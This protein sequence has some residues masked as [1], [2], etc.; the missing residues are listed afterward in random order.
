MMANA[1]ATLAASACALAVMAVACRGADPAPDRTV[2]GRPDGRSRAPAPLPDLSRM[3]ASVR[4]QLRARHASLMRMR[5][6]ARVS[7]VELGQAYG[8]M[9][10]LLMA[11]ELPGA[12]E[13]CF[14]QA[15]ALVPGEMRWPYYL[16]HVHRTNGDLTG[17]ISSFERA[18]ELARDDEAT[19]MWLGLVYLEQGRPDAA[20][21]PFSRALS[22]TP[23]NSAAHF[24][25][26]RAALSRHEYAKAVTHL[27][28][29]LAIAPQAT[30]VHYS[31]ALAYRGTGDVQNADAHMR[32][33]GQADV[34]LRDPLMEEVAGLLE[35]PVS[36]QRRGVQALGR[37]AWAEAASYFR[38]GLDLNPS[39]PLLR[40]SL[41]HKLGTALF[42]M[43]DMRSALQQF[44]QGARSSPA[45]APNH[46]SLGVI[47]A[48]SG[49]D[50]EAI[51]HFSTAL[52]HDAGY[53]E[54]HLHLADALRRA[55]RVEASRASYEAAL[56]IDPRLAE[57][58]FGSA[59]A[60]VRLGR[61]QEAATR[62][63]EGMARHPEQ[64]RFTHAL[65]RLIAAA[66]DDRVRDGRRAL[67]LTENLQ[68]GGTSVDLA[69]TIAMALAELGRYG[70]ATGWQRQVI[71]AVEETGGNTRRLQQL[72]DTLAGY[73]RGI[74]C[75]M[76]W[77]GD[78]PIHTPGPPV[79]AGVLG[80]R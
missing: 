18:R 26:G 35:S 29:A 62:L 47:M 11:A 17:A 10:R 19:L 54:A 50:P 64:R 53:A 79:Q 27:E 14:L 59:M 48:M 75:R 5:E 57:A 23:R 3:D 28:S 67:A 69:E 76:P 24:G 12:A 21:L 33:Q 41:H 65:A 58:R 49:R 73:E 43:G 71:A 60:L 13:T 4:E 2:V 70:D 22:L 8:E 46:A 66:Q 34:D 74:P 39:S 20:E 38:R 6:N 52:R 1:S 15:Q 68:K 61:E 32:Q 25:L 30:I 72:R 31:L 80:P 36:Y 7:P 37:E 77:S 44:E 56:R 55:D 63:T 51:Q 16:G 9:G 45:Y 42:H 78:D 40:D